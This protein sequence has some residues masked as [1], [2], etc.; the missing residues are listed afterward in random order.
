MEIAGALGTLGPDAAPARHV[1]IG[2]KTGPIFIT[3]DPERDT[4]DV[5]RNAPRRS[6]DA[7]SD[8][9][10]GCGAHD[11]PHKTGDEDDL[12]DHGTYL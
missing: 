4:P 1:G 5:R 8:L 2:H 3:V 9:P 6:I 12:V 11:A 10:A 7:S